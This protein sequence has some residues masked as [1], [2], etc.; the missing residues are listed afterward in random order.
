[1]LIRLATKQDI[2]MWKV[3]SNEYNSYILE[4]STDFSKWYQGFEEYMSR[5][6]DQSE[7]LIAVEIT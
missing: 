1:M 4:I 6:I 3:L 5:K 7:A 2:P